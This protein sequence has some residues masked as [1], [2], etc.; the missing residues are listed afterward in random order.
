MFLFILPFFFLSC[1]E[2]TNMRHEPRHVYESEI[3]CKRRPVSRKLFGR[4]RTQHYVAK[5]ADRAMPGP[6]P[7]GSSRQRGAFCFLIFM[8]G[9]VPR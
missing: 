8:A 7:V 1:S 9:A 5:R 6:V 4:S 3:T 2:S